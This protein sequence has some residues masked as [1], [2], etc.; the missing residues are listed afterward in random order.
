MSGW[1]RKDNRVESFVINLD[2]SPVGI[3]LQCTGKEP[4]VMT[5]D[6]NDVQIAYASGRDNY[7]KFIDG[8]TVTWDTQN[9]FNTQFYCKVAAGV[10]AR[11]TFMI[12]GSVNE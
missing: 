10:D 8:V 9:P 3:D 5:V 12:G 7:I 6:G 2:A 1:K 4:I 11:V